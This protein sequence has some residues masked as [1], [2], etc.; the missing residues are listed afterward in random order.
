[1]QPHAVPYTPL[2]PDTHT[3]TY[4]IHT[5]DTLRRRDP[6]YNAPPPQVLLGVD[7]M[8][9]FKGIELKLQAFERLLEEHP[10]WRGKVVLVQV[11]GG[12]CG[13]C[14]MTGGLGGTFKGMHWDGMGWGG[15]GWARGPG[16]KGRKCCRT[17]VLQ[18]LV[19]NGLG[20]SS[21]MAVMMT[22]LFTCPCIGM[23]KVRTWP[24]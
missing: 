23:V 2:A 13:G 22:C 17:V 1:V 19:I 18:C 16:V 10:E 3:H 12:G 15:V 21:A 9:V 5:D 20:P 24:Y 7:D 6:V 14:L 4:D 11:R 8:D